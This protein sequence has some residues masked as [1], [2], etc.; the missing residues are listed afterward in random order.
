MSLLRVHPDDADPRVFHDYATPE[1]IQQ[2]VAPPG[3]RFDRWAVHALSFESPVTAGGTPA[4]P[5]AILAAYQDGVARLQ[6]A[7]GFVTA[8]VVSVSSETPNHPAL[9]RKFLSEHTHTEDEARFFVEGAGLFVIHHERSVYCLLCERG[10]LINVPAGTRHWFDMGPRPRFTAIRFFTKPEGWVA[11]FT[12]S[13]VAERF[14]RLAEDG[15]LEV[16]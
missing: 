5:A 14:P 3:I 10:D 8:D 6:R 15:G 4:P 9:R 11:Q 12:G 1:A 2:N 7:A 16:P 13:E